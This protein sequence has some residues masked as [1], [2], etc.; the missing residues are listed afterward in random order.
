MVGAQHLHQV[1]GPILIVVA[2]PYTVLVQQWC[3]E[4]ELFGLSPINLTL[5]A[6]P[7]GREQAIADARRRLR[8]GLT[9]AE[10]LVVS[11]D[12]LCT[13]DFIEQVGRY[14]G[15]K[16]LIADE[17]HNLGVSGFA[18][19]PP[20]IFDYRL[21]LSATP[22]RQYD[23]EGTAFLF[24][25]F[26]PT[27]FSFQLEQAIGRC[28][29]PYDY[30]AHFV[31]LRDDEMAEWRDL[32]DQIARLAWK[33]DAGIKDERLEHL[34]LKRRRVL[35][36]A[37][38]KLDRLGE[39][40]D[41]ENL[42]TIRYTLI[43]ATDKDPRQLLRVNE[44]LNA[45]ELK[46]HQLTAEETADKEKSQRILSSFQAGDLQILTA[47]RVLDEGVNVPQ[48]ERAY[49][50]ASTTVRRQWVQRRGR[51]LRMCKEIGKTHAI[52]HDLVALPPEAYA[53]Q[54][55]D[56]DARKVVRSELDRVWEFARLSR[57]G[58]RNGGPFEQVERLKALLRDGD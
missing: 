22:V 55:I 41:A 51:L 38:Q 36:T 27:C 33:I 14:D 6:G 49:I 18:N 54:R 17:C 48:I 10:A 30:F 12:T 35:E 28:L 24:D 4:I 11:I 34:L 46:F 44:M 5:E 39:L 2:A 23:D 58:A 52:I 16:L 29:T 53:G 15:P 47:K 43:Y 42:R 20:V 21:G 3:G 1:V 13:P 56:A 31:S 26:G 9:P 45:R 57:N 19:S 32:S 7:K 37:E 8:M 25:Y 40:L 50:L